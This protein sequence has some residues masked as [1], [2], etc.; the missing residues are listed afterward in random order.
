MLD[1]QTVKL[2]IMIKKLILLSVL[3]SSSIALAQ[4][5]PTAVIDQKIKDFFEDF[6]RKDTLELKSYFDASASLQ[7]VVKL[8]DGSTKIIEEPI[9]K[10]VSS[11]GSIPDS[12]HFEERISKASIQIAKGLVHAFV[13]YEFYVDKQFSH[14]GV[15]SFIFVLIE[16]QWLISNIIDTRNLTACQ[17]DQT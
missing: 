6:H 13:P 1:F 17:T 9:A 12:I 5:D 11:I 16:D 15:N 8:K 4:K 10:F 7:S 2:I 3:L 14:C